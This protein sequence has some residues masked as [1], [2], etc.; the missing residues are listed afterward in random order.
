MF[1]KICGIT[2]LEDAQNAALF[3]ANAIGFVFAKSP[4]QISPEK[5]KE[6]ISRIGKDI[7]KIGVFVDEALDKLEYTAGF[8]GLD[9]VQLHGNENPDYCSKIQ[10]EANPCPPAGA[11]PSAEKI[12]K[13]IKVFRMKN[14][15]S[16]F[17]MKNYNSVFAYLLDSF[18]KDRYGG[19][20]RAFDWSL[21]VKAKAIGK[22]I[23]LSGGIGLSNVADAIRVVAPYGVD[24]SSSIEAEPGKKDPVLMKRLIDFIRGL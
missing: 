24:I 20:G 1:I 9:A 4:R 5:A 18:S 12:G 6:I 17:S 22:P 2:N 3:G 10:P 14:E 13:V 21:A 7:I 23:I 11:A 8:C 19:T 16:L 15:K